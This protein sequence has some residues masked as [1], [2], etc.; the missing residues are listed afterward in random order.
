MRAAEVDP[1]SAGEVALSRAA[2]NEAREHFER[3]VLEEDSAAAWEGLS[4]ANW[5]LGDTEPMFAAR[6]RAFRAFRQAED[7]RGA[8][9]IAAWLANDAVDFRGEH[10]VASGWLERA[11]RL[12]A[13]DRRCPEYGWLL[14]LDGYLSLKLDG[15]VEA[16]V[17]RG[18]AAAALGAELGVADLEALG[19]AVEGDSLVTGGAIEEGLRCLDEAAAL[20]ATEEFEYP[21]ITPAFT[22][23][24]LI[25]TC[26]KAGDFGRVA[27]WCEAMRAIGEQ[28][29]GRHVV[30][31]CRSA[32][33]NVLTARGEW[34]QAELELT[35]A[36]GA[37][38]AT[39]PG[40]A[41]AGL[42]RL[43]ELRVRQGRAEEARELFER[44]GAEPMALTG[45]GTLSLQQGDAREAAEVAERILRRPGGP[46]DRVPPLELL[47]RARHRLG[48]VEA[49]AAALDR[50][51]ALVAGRPTPY[52]S[53]RVRL[54]AGELAL[55]GGEAESARRLLEDAV[56]FF[57]ESSA[58]Y[59]GA[60][61]RLTL[62]AA[63]AR[64]GRAEA[65]EREAAAAAARFAELGAS[66]DVE[67]AERIGKRTATAPGAEAEGAEPGE[68]TPRELEVLR[69]VAQGMSDAEIAAQLVVS[70][71]TVHRHVANV[72]TKLR[73]PSRAAAVAYA[74]RE[75]LI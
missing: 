69:L 53:G 13:E 47:A 23:C 20:A 52:L 54:V 49:A 7:A 31:V 39:R 6:E 56:D 60:L 1:R 11:R 64:L 59:E 21:T 16:G 62:A 28:L 30:G 35:D 38:E 46:L 36:L 72:R 44:A 65:A 19:R 73:L 45:L 57:A 66:A 75:G 34:P 8:A 42:V 10:A 14:F 18:R 9:R 2:W 37:L 33:G 15:D 25:S 61:A 32:Y 22:Q 55:A 29:D 58:P 43:G 40:L 26:E 27:Q 41:P 74:A 71:H 67:R 4:W 48:E 70:P 51:E 5:W 68:L 17:E 12:L 3:A 63:L 24:I 50:L